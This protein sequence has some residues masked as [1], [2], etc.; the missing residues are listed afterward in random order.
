M[1]ASFDSKLTFCP[2]KSLHSRGY[3]SVERWLEN[4][5]G[6]IKCGL[7]TP[8][9]F[10]GS[11][12]CRAGGVENLPRHRGAEKGALQNQSVI[13]FEDISIIQNQLIWIWQLTQL[14]VV[15]LATEAA[16]PTKARPEI[17]IMDETATGKK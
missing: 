6:V 1:A 17:F 15:A 5:G 16:I 7:Q 14:V 4:A 2:S 12:V 3:V 9:S 8:E 13:W 11:V 10:H